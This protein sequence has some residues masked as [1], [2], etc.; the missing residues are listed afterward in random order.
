[1]SKMMR[2]FNSTGTIFMNACG[3]LM[4]ILL[5]ALSLQAQTARSRN[6]VGTPEQRAARYFESIRKSP[7]QMLAFLLLMPKGGDLHNHLSGS[8]YAESYVQWAAAKGLCVNQ[9]SMALSQPPCDQ[10]AGQVPANNALSNS[11]LYRQ[12]I[13]V[14]SLRYWEYSGQNGHDKFFDTFGKFGAATFGQ[15]GQMLADTASRAA[16][17][18]VLYLELMLTPDGVMSGQIGQKV[19]WDG[20]FAGT[21]AKLKSSGIDG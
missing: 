18:H 19:G 4:L 20:N 2:R 13:D 7:P 11:L 9:N 6:K 1:M 14:W 10:A 8:V 12:L 5:C 17:G 3:A 15:T 16:R 21:L